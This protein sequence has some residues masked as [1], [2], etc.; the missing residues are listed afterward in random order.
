[1]EPTPRGVL[2]EEGLFLQPHHLQQQALGALSLAARHVSCAAPH[3]WGI[4]TIDVDPLQLENGVFEVRALEILLPS[5]DL[6]VFRSGGDGNARIAPREIPKVA[7]SRLTVY[8]GVRRVR[9]HEPNVREPD[10]DDLDPPRWVRETRTVADLTTGRNLTDVH[11]LQFNARIF[12]EGDRMDGFETIPIARLAAPAVGL[13]LTRLAPGYAPPALRLSASGGAH[14]MVRE[15]YAEAAAKAAELASAATVADFLAGHASEAE[16]VQLLKLGVLRGALPH[17]RDAADGGL[18]H[19]ADAYLMLCGF[20]GQFST[21][22]AGAGAPNVPLYNHLEAGECFE[23]VSSAVLSLLRQDQLA[24]NF[25]RIP[26]TRGTLPFGG[27]AVGAQGLDPEILAGRNQFYV[28]FTNPDP[29]GPERDWYRSGHVKVAA[30][31]RISNTVVQ[32]KYGVPLLP[33][34]KP[35]VLPARAGAIYY[36]LQSDAAGRAEVQAEWEAVVRER[37]LV[38]HFATEGLAP[39]QAAPD[40]GMEAYVVFGR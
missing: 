38:V 16:L 8:A 34:P 36:R 39:G 21:F 24:A 26:L 30:A 20:L 13:P 11:F 27:L 6:L 33:C 2:W 9:E 5:G 4:A 18:V 28:V 19:P 32:R 10:G 14:A 15:V 17:L 3:R 40:L 22:C 25:R 1:M 29:S 7:E 12:F 35:R 31:T 37:T 23:L